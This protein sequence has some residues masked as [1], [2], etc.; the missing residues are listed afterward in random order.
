MIKKFGKT[1]VTADTIDVTGVACYGT[2]RKRYTVTVQT[3]KS[4]VNEI[5]VVEFR[6]MDFEIDVSE[7]EY[8]KYRNRFFDELY[9]K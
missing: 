2:I 5:G 8:V 3:T 6:R 4:M 1:I 7:E 9:C